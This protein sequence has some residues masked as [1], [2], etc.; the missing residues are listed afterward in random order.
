MKKQFLVVALVMAG[1]LLSACGNW[2]NSPRIV[3]ELDGKIVPTTFTF[4]EFK[5]TLA[6][7]HGSVEAIGQEQLKTKSLIVFFK[8]LPNGA[9]LAERAIMLKSAQPTPP[10]FLFGLTKSIHSGIQAPQ[11][12]IVVSN[13]SW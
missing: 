4:D 6:A 13:F 1:C 2:M 12:E 8:P 10:A 3:C 7:E 11:S 9:L 5:R